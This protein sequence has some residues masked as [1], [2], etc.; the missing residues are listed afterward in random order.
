MVRVALGVLLLAN[1]VAAAFAFH[2]IGASPDALNQQ[3]SAAL[4]EEQTSQA[5]LNR[6]RLLTSNIDKGKD[7]GDKFLASYMTSRRYTY[8]TIIGELNDSSK[9]SGMKM[10]DATIAPLDPIEG[11]DD[12]DMMTISVN[13]DGGYNDLVKLV[14]LLDRSKRFLILESLAVTPRPKGDSLS[15]NVRLNAFVKDD[16][17]ATL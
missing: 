9:S 17:A 11:S 3:V 10:L 16:K 13:F 7:E 14:N 4:T 8:S 5:K 6:S 2:L 1:L 12:M 15:V